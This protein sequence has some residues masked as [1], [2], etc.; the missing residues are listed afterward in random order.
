MTI[1]STNSKLLVTEDWQ[2]LYQSFPNAEFQSYDFDTI[3]R[4]LITYLQE[5]YPEDF[6]DFIESSEYIALV[7]LIAY[8]G[9]N[10]SF[11]IDLNARENFLETAQ[12][13]DSILRLAQLVSYIPKRNVPASGLLKISAVSTTGNVFD[14]TGSNL[15][16]NTIVWNDS[17]NA[18]WYEQ[19]M[20]IINSTMPNTMMFGNP[21]DSNTIGGILTQQYIINSSNTDVPVYTF[22]QNINGSST[23]FELV[24]ST[25]SGQNYVYEE[26][27]KPANPIKIIYQND[28]QGSS[29]PN[30]GF[31]LLFK[32]GVLA[33]SNFSLVNPVPNEIVGINVS[34][35]NNSDVWLWQL[36]PNGDYTTL[37][38][39]VPAISGNNVIY[40]SLSQND[41][42]IYSLS[43][44]DQDQIDVNFSDGS[45]GNLP[46]G[47]FQL[48]Y[49]QSNGGTYS[50]TP[51]Q[52]SGI[53]VDIP[54]VDKSGINQ[55]LTLIL[56]LEYT[57]SNSAPTETNTSIQ[58]KAPQQYYTQNRMITAE[59]YNIAPLTYTTNVLKVK[60]VNRVSS[61]ISKYFELS[62]VSGKYSSTNIFGD[63]GILSK[64]TT[65][66]SFTFSFSGQNAIWS[67][68]QKQ[69][70]PVVASPELRSFYLDAYR[71]YEPIIISGQLNYSWHLSQNVA[72]QSR[73]YFKGAID[74]TSVYPVALGPTYS[75]SVYPSYYITSGS[76]IKFIAPLSYYGDTQYFL[77][78]GSLT[79]T[80]SFN[81][82]E[83]MWG[84]I[85]QII[86]TGSNNGLG[87]L[88]DGTGPVIF[89]NSVPNGAIPVE[90]VPPFPATLDYTL[91]SNIVNLCSNNTT[92]GLTI[93]PSTR[94]WK[95]I[96]NSNLDTTYDPSNISK[97]FDHVG[98][99]S[100]THLDASWLILFKW[101]PTSN[102]YCVTTKTTQYIFQ[103]ENQTGFYIDT[104]KNNFDYINN[105]VVRDKITVLSVN[106][107]PN[108]GGPLT[109]DYL[110]QIDGNIVEADG[111]VD[112]STVVVSFYNTLN[113]QQFNQIINPDSFNNIVGNNTVSIILN[114][115]TTSLIPGKSGIKFQYQ[116][117][118]SNEVR[119]DPAK[120]NIIDIYMLTADYDSAFRNW[121][122]TGATGNKP[123]APT[124]QDLENNYSANLEPIKAI[125]DQIIYQPATYK[126]LFGSSAEPNL[127]ATFKAVVS[128]SST[129]SNNA[130]TSKILD[131][132][133]SFF[134]LENWDFGQS[135]FFSELSTYIMN[136]LTPDITNFLIIPTS[137]G[138]G[139]LYEVTCQN[140]EIFISGAVSSDIQVISA[141]SAAQLK[142]SSGS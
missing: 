128:S 7:E 43:T 123:I 88:S 112:P 116:H 46:N 30:T 45:F 1:P 31:F 55:T 141:A 114:G 73:G 33:T 34:N 32:Q 48:F 37:W 41:R 71:T 129:L 54:Y 119:V 2:K 44:R 111:Y 14:S 103:S 90:I 110:W 6:N 139:N 39:Q 126:V 12:R 77:P 42:N 38:S 17:T 15:S 5:N 21:N 115:V 72:G 70:N 9:Q 10:L 40:N 50:I 62:D 57:V 19:F 133:N 4:I 91:E 104:S 98:D 58:Q 113:S 125:S 120:S 87:N 92:F 83:Y 16:G 23:D 74:G 127:Q 8:L 96:F 134:A 124:T 117:N 107:D 131:G 78:D 137:S 60:S 108:S 86:G 67:A 51:D 136:L 102:N 142:I 68:I 94:H 135:F 95:F 29:S 35:I 118:P 28:N 27:P 64:N 106:Q 25:F 20:T 80:K 47:N 75:N 69:L 132:I 65:S 140:N 66:T 24:S 61:G 97:M 13:R 130:I 101:Q 100:G 53:V 93:D 79:T 18:N 11:R 49:R 76:M 36:T 52:M 85:E 121:L 82:S 3:R 99:V 59:D 26:T 122:L 138:F 105:S 81:A 109:T 22:N 63:D 89:A 84:T 56:N